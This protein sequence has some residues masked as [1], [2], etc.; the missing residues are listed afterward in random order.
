MPPMETGHM[1]RFWDARAREDAF[2]FV[3][4]TGRYGAPDTERFWSSGDETLAAFSERLG[5]SVAPEDV[6]L[7]IGCGIGRLTR[8][9]AG[10]AREVLALDVSADMLAQAKEFNSHLANVTWLQGDGM[11]LA[12]VEPASVDAIVSFVVFQHIPD[13]AITLGYVRE[14]GRVLRPGG[15][16]A[17]QIS[18]DPGVHE[19]SARPPGLRAR[20]A[21]LLGRAPRGQNDPAWLGSAIDLDELAA[22]A[23]SAGMDVERVEGAGQQFCFVVLRRRA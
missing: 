19:G 11:S 21:A 5:V 7:D 1:R 9:L 13:P 4:N 6:V 10:R 3:D 23:D 8:A 2:F 22:V 18:N 12:S 17:F 14:M 16:S 15:W 20:L